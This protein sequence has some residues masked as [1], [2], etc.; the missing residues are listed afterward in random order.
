MAPHGLREN[1]RWTVALKTG[2][3]FEVCLFGG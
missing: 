1:R 2:R 3:A